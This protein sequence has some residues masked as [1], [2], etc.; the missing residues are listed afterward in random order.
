MAYKDDGDALLAQLVDL[1]HAALRE[2]DVADRQRF[3]DDQ[4]LGVE[5]HGDGER[6]P[7]DHA[8]RIGFERLV[9][10]L[11]DLGERQ[12]VVE[13]RF[14]LLGR[15]AQE[16]PVEEDILAAAELVVEARAKLQQGIDA[17]TDLD[18]AAGRT[19][20]AADDLKQRGLAGA[21]LAD[22]AEGFAL[23]DFERYIL[24]GPVLGVTRP[25]AKR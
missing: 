18:R 7:N 8:A 10:E 21:V 23:A 11:A 24:Q 6:Q 13:F 25:A 5:L 2:I 20:D 14:D 3:V 19:D 16:R 1:P 22:D 17:A 12:D 4:D 9:D 15:E